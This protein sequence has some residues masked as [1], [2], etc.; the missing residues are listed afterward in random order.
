MVKSNQFRCVS[1][2]SLQV[3][4][5]LLTHWLKSAL[6][7]LPHVGLDSIVCSSPGKERSFFHITLQR[8]EDHC[9]ALPWPFVLRLNSLGPF[10][11]QLFASS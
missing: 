11:T 1:C 7:C 6:I 8:V 4:E 10:K 9:P 3:R 2:S 5:Y